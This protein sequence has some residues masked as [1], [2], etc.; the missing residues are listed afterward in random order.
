VQYY[1]MNGEAGGGESAFL[2]K[3]Q[4]ATTMKSTSVTSR[5]HAAREGLRQARIILL[6]AD[7]FGLCSSRRAATARTYAA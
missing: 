7:G 1:Q 6:E 4:N 5:S 2:Q 3:A